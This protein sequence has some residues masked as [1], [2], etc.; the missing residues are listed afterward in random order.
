MWSCDYVHQE[1]N[2]GYGW[3]AKKI[4]LD[5]V[6]EDDARAILGGTAMKLFKL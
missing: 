6:S 3:R 1:S 4:V 5:T 2:F